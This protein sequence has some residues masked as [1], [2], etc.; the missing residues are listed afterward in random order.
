MV[1]NAVAFED[2]A[3]AY[4]TLEFEDVVFFADTDVLFDDVFVDDIAGLE[5]DED[6]GEF[7]GN[8][9]EVVAYIFGDENG[10]FLG[11]GVSVLVDKGSNPV[12]YLIVVEFGT[13][14]DAT[15]V[16]DGFVGFGAFVKFFVAVA[17]DE[18]SLRKWSLE[19]VGEEFPLLSRDFL[20]LFDQ[21]DLDR[22][23]HGELFG[24]AYDSVHVGFAPVE[25]ILVEIAEVGRNN[26]MFKEIGGE[27]NI[28]VFFAC[29]Q[30]NGEVFACFKVVDKLFVRYEHSVFI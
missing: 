29:E 25:Y 14:A 6:F 12:G 20:S 21:D 1:D 2:I 5:R 28:I 13:F 18:K 26:V 15:F 3:A 16:V 7:V 30:I 27:V 23:H 9:G 4:G 24:V 10:A 17:K 11:D 19:I 22:G 8:F